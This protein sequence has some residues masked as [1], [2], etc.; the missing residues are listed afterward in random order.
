MKIHS[1]CVHACS[2]LITVT[3]WVTSGMTTSAQ[4]R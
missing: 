3:P 1:G 2:L 4:T